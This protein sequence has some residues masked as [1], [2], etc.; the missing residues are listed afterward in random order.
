[1]SKSHPS[2]GSLEPD[3]E[4]DEPEVEVPAS[5]SSAVVPKDMSS[6]VVPRDPLDRYFAE[7][8]KYPLLTREEELELATRVHESGD[9]EAAEKL[10]LSNLRLVIKIAMEYRRVWTNLPDLTPEGNVGLLKGVQR[11]DPTRGVKLSSYAAYWIRA[12]ILKHLIDNIRL[13]RVGSSRAERK[14]FFQLNRARRELERDGLE[15]SAKLLAEKL[16][17]KEP[18]VV[19]MEHRLSNSDLSID[20]PSRRDEADSS[21]FGDFIPTDDQPVDEIVGDREV[22]E[23]FL[24]HIEAFSEQ[25]DEREKAIISQRLIADPDD[26]KTLQEIGEQFSLTRERVRQIE[27]KLVDKLREYLKDKLVDFDYWG[28]QA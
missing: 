26:A 9:P 8:G 20:A 18:E 10:V 4:T 27:K 6:D 7:V 13:V 23:T 14:L 24:R 16:G 15:P 3:A 5:A 25:L 1:M 28:P 21:S 2:P 11:Y 19:D 12:Y 17:V 22:R